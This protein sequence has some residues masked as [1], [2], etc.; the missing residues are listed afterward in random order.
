MNLRIIGISLGRMALVQQL[1]AIARALV[2]PVVREILAYRIS[3]MAPSG[4]QLLWV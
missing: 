4:S 2:L 1:D 3:L